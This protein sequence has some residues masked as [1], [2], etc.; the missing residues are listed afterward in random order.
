MCDGGVW[1]VFVLENDCTRHALSVDFIDAADMCTVVVQGGLEVPALYGV[2][3]PG[4]AC[5]GILMF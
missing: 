4:G 2:I 5:V 3:V 1:Y